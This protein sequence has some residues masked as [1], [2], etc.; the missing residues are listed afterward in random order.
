VEI[1]LIAFEVALTKEKFDDDFQSLKTLLQSKETYTKSLN[2][3]K[4]IWIF[5][6]IWANPYK[7]IIFSAGAHTTSRAESM[8]A[9][10]KR[11]TGRQSELSS[12]I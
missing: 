7:S 2:Y 9:L 1:C 11:Y 3:L 6:E 5:K 10:V 12:I 8:N 4:D